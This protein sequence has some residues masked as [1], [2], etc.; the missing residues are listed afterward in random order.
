MKEPSLIKSKLVL[1]P[2]LSLIVV[3][4]FASRGVAPVAA[5]AAG[6][7]DAPIVGH[8]DRNGTSAPLMSITPLAPSIGGDEAGDVQV[9]EHPLGLGRKSP[10][11]GKKPL[12]DALLQNLVSGTMP[13]PI[14]KFDGIGQD[15]GCLPPDTNGDV[16]PHHYVQFINTSFEI[17]DKSG[18][19][20]YGPAAGNTLFHNFGGP[21][22]KTNDGDPIVLYDPLA[23]RWLF[24][25]FA[26]PNY[27]S[28]P[29]YQCIAISTGS[30]PATSSYYLYQFTASD[31][32]LNDYPKFGVW[33]DG[34]YMTVNQFDGDNW[35]GTGAFVFDRA[36]MLVGNPASFQKFNL[37]P[38]T[39][40]GG[41]LPS[42][43]DGATAP[44]AGAPNYFIEVNDDA[45]QTGFSDELLVRQFHVDWT[46]PANTT[47][48]APTHLAVSPFD[49]VVCN[50]NRRNCIPQKGTTA[51]LDVISDR[52]MNRLAYRN[53]GDHESLVVNHTV[54]VDGTKHAGIRWYELRLPGGVPTIYQ[55]GT[56]APD[57]RHRWMASA[58]MDKQGNLALGFSESASDLYPGVY[59]VG[60]LASDP[61]GTLPQAET[62]LK[63]GK[64]AQTSSYSRWGD[65][66]M[67]AVDPSD[68]CTFWYTNEYYSSVSSIN[69]KTRIGA[70]KFP[71]CL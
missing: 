16:G 44:P 21:C 50:L 1:V 63:K 56:Y 42:D 8:S 60:R 39:D 29:F 62:S 7:A 13:S 64:G 37:D 51:K 32:L 23:K 6:N 48:S 68:D 35:A 30:N 2:L 53:F 57:A 65:Y 49:G 40:W 59:Y 11:P 41:M 31:T 14:L 12:Q 28:G 17:F 46:T 9:P 67:M 45:W 20:V 38:A 22:E 47:F 25:Q 66:S 10:P 36:N 54:D 33:H 5:Q 4:M 58:A 24:S 26:L 18:A 52:L 34:Y 69:W 43:L 15:C 70:F 27:P 55:Q 71:S 61:L 19:R 3:L